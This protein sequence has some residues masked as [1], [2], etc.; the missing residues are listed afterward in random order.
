MLIL[1]DYE[2]VIL[3]PAK[4]GTRSF[5]TTIREQ[6]IK[7]TFKG[8]D[9]TLKQH[10][11][12]EECIDYFIKKGLEFE[13][14]TK[15]IPVRNP[16]RRYY[17][18]YNY[19]KSKYVELKNAKEKP[20]GGLEP[21]QE[22]AFRRMEQTL[23]SP[24]FEKNETGL[25]HKIITNEI[26]NKKALRDYI[27]LPNGKIPNK[28]EFIKFEN[29]KEDFKK[30]IIHISPGKSFDLLHENIYKYEIDPPEVLFRKET[31]DLIAKEERQIIKDF[32]YEFDFF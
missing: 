27:Y 10:T 24:I 11:N 30:A 16:W 20:G 25:F 32:N 17:S 18:L 12:L 26:R 23:K 31:I 8:T 4:T 13:K 21:S 6:K 1:N 7:I 29:I 14:Y 22:D 15:F 19:L 28:T 9:P 3:N 2:I 5:R